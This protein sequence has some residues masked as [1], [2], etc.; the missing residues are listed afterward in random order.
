MKFSCGER[1][2]RFVLHSSGSELFQLVIVSTSG[3]LSKVQHVI[4]YKVVAYAQIEDN[5]RNTCNLVSKCF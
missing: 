5:Q 4:L 1:R 3:E 2:D